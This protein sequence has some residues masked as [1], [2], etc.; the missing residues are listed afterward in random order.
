[1]LAQHLAAEGVFLAHGH[2]A[3]A[4]RLGGQIDP[5]DPREKRQRRKVRHF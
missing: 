5:A 4:R 1:M 2:G 3:D